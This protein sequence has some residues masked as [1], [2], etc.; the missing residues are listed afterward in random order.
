MSH[1]AINGVPT[2]AALTQA[3]NNPVL[4]KTDEKTKK[5]SQG[6]FTSLIKF[7]SFLMLTVTFPIS[8][9]LLYLAGKVK[10]FSFSS[11]IKQETSNIDPTSSALTLQQS[12]SKKEG[13]TT[14]NPLAIVTLVRSDS[15]EKVVEA[16]ASPL[17]QGGNPSLGTEEDL[18][19]STEHEANYNKMIASQ[20]VEAPASSLSQG[21]NPSLDT[22]EDLKQSTEY[23]ANY[24]K[25]IASQNVEAPASPASQSPISSVDAD[26]VLEQSDIPTK[27]SKK[28][29]NKTVIAS[30]NALLPLAVL[31]AIGYFTSTGFSPTEI[32]LNAGNIT[33]NIS[34][35]VP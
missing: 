2:P 23:E 21:G 34:K 7:I 3:S 15:K 20:Y 32:I 24:N 22:E 8:L 16:P 17:S 25:I 35:L 10:D 19:Q 26:E 28:I 27:T 18:E 31:T 5:V 12:D 1:L 6:F 33:R 14:E 29:V 30:I 13:N 11:K 4:S 9:P